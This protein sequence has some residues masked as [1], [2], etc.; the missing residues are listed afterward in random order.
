MK[1]TVIGTGYVG[2]VMGAGLAEIGHTVH[3]LDRDSA[4][5]AELCEGRLPIHEPGLEELYARNMEEERLFFTTDAAKAVGESL[6]IFL[7]VGTPPKPDGRVDLGAVFEAAETIGRHMTGYRIVVNKST[8]PPGTADAVRERIAGLTS[9][10]FDVVANPEFLR[11]G[12]AVDDFMRPDRII[13][14]ADDVRVLEIMRE[15]YAPLLRTGNPFLSMTV[16]SAELAKYAV[17]TML[18]S[19]ISMINQFAQLAEVYGADVEEV[20]EALATDRRIGGAYIYPGLGY[21]GSC[22][23][24]DIRACEQLA[25]DGGVSGDLFEAIHTTNERQLERF[26]R[27]ILDYYGSDLAQKH[28]ALWGATFKARTDDI[29]SAPALRVI[30]ALLDAGAQVTAYDPAA[31]ERLKAAYGDRVRVAQKTYAALEGADGLVITTEWREFQSPDYERMAGLLRDRVIF[32][33]RNLYS[34]K[35]MAEHGFRYISIGRPA[36]GK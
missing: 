29:R 13:V 25:R 31:G 10:D 24:K 6:V 14:G 7:C 4:L 32:D 34:P 17:N 28:I 21:G 35:T 2:L 20:R 8:C 26:I 5:I 16:R 19:R 18:A 27:R 1:I 9:H 22:L 36:T 33:G 11:E 12:S 23:P 30:D 15:L 3:C